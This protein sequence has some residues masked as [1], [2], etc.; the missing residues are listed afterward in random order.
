MI[1]RWRHIRRLWAEIFR[2]NPK[3]GFWERV[4]IL[5]KALH[6]RERP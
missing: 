1:E 5:D 6:L 3:A 2:Q 4:R